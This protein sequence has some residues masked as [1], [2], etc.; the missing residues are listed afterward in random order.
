MAA[1]YAGQPDLGPVWRCGWMW[2]ADQTDAELNILNL[3]NKVVHRLSG[4]EEKRA[5]RGGQ[6]SEQVVSR[7]QD[8][9]P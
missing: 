5:G 4:V 2:E 3:R 7:I 6:R 9:C 1:G 8:L